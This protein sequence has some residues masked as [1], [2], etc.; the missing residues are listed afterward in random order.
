MTV[1]ICS[2]ISCKTITND[3]IILAPVNPLYPDPLYRPPTCLSTTT[4][5]TCDVNAADN[6]AYSGIDTFPTCDNGQSCTTFNETKI[7]VSARL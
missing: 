4:Y 3:Q 1:T 2:A 5:A 6:P 7:E